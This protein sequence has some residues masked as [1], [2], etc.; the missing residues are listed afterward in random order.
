MSA[1]TGIIY[2]LSCPETKQ[3]RYIGQTINSIELRL[4]QH[5]WQSIKQHNH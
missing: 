1:N 2:S 5:L 4:K 3:I